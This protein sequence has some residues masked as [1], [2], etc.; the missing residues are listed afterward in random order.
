MLRACTLGSG[1]SFFTSKYTVAL[2]V[3]TLENYECSSTRN[4]YP[5]L[6]FSTTSFSYH[7]PSLTLFVPKISQLFLSPPFLSAL[8]FQVMDSLLHLC[9]SLLLLSLSIHDCRLFVKLFPFLL[10]LFLAIFTSF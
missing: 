2:G 1:A 10:K 6:L 3:L 4:F 9:L 8:S 5:L 7:F